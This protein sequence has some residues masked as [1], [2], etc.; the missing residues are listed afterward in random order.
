MQQ[1]KSY[2][3]VF[4]SQ[5]STRNRM[6]EQTGAN[7]WTQCRWQQERVVG[8]SQITIQAPHFHFSCQRMWCVAAFCFLSTKFASHHTRH[9]TISQ[10]L[11]RKHETQKLRKLRS[12]TIVFLILFPKYCLLK[13]VLQW[14]QL[15]FFLKT[16]FT[17]FNSSNFYL[18]SVQS[19]RVLPE[20]LSRVSQCQVSFSLSVVLF[21]CLNAY[22]A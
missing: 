2:Q 13:S 11:N 20:N 17:R 12:R 18:Y 10:T 3:G 15:I 6:M 5:H 9:E 14:L 7:S 16:I 22:L 4:W 19:L 21:L 8:P 1:P